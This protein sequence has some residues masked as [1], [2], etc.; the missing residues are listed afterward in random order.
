MPQAQERVSEKPMRQIVEVDRFPTLPSVAMEAIRLMEGEHSSFDSIADLLKS[1]QVLAGRI[2]HYANS[3]YIGARQ[4]VTSISQAIS[5]LGFN[6]LRSIIL[7]VS[8]FDCFTG[9]LAR[10]KKNLVNFWLHSIGVAATAEILAE[11]LGFESPAEAYVAGL[12]H[13]LGKLVCYLESPTDFEKVCQELEQQG[14]YSV[15]QS[16]PLDVERNIL[17]IRHIEAGK[18]LGNQW[19]LPEALVRVM[20]LHH[21]PVF[22]TI[23]PDP[24]NLPQLIRFADVLCVTHNVGSSYFMTSG[25]YCHEHFHFA[26]E[27]LVLHHHLSPAEIDE[28]MTQV[29]ERV[30]EVSDV[31]GIWNEREYRKLVGSANVSLG[32]LSR[33][34][35]RH[36][37]RLVQSNQV[38]EAICEISRQFNVSSSLPETARAVVSSALKGFNV[39]RCLCLIRDEPNHQFIGKFFDGADYHDV[40]IPAH[41]AGLKEYTLNS[42]GSDIELEA[43]QRLEQT[44]VELS[45]GDTFGPGV[46]KIV[47]GSQFLATFFVA[48]SKSYYGENRI[49]GELVVDFSDTTSFGG[50]SLK[51]V[52]KHFEAFASAAGNAVQNVLLQSGLTKHAQEVA[53]T[54]R[55]MEESQRQLFHS[56]RLATVGRLAAGAAHEINNPLTIISLNIQIID[57]LL[58]KKKEAKELRDRLTVIAEQ[59]TRIS[60]IIQDLMGFARP[61]QPKFY[62]SS[63]AQIME[64]VLS[65]IEDRVSMT[66]ISIANKI[67]ADL[68]M[69]MVDPMQVEQVFMNLLINANH[70]MPD[71]GKITLTAKAT[72]GFVEVNVTD[73]GLGIPKKNLA[74]IFDPFFT[75]KKEGEGTGLGLAICNSIVEHNGGSL[76]VQ[77]EEGK[78]TS[79]TVQLPVD[80]GSRLRAMKES[81]E[82]KKTTAAKV[83]KEKCRILVIDDERILNDM[84]QDSLRSSGY[85]VDGA[86]DGVEGIGLLRYKKYHLVLLDIRMPR[87]D[88]LEVLKFIKDE[89]P[90]IKVIMVTGL[91]SKEEVRETVK[92]GAFACLKKPFRLE[93]VLETVEQATRTECSVDKRKKA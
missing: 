13:D 14:A 12:T 10:H 62:P 82:Q 70:A 19:G 3:I 16:L 53:E 68:P 76:R 73:T 41:V 89:Y 61:T 55:K 87:K 46:M 22:E 79:F 6:A 28:I 23:T 52:T 77:S 59:E 80:K 47:A 15:H 26:L 48:D 85:D 81:M 42:A 39:S 91:A 11:K 27:N 60:K 30:K 31:L 8:I 37:R 17:G 21:Q 29:H 5:L 69:I 56:H 64:K 83:E 72:N 32:S 78:G 86:Y 1:D 34:L 58:S 9:K 2:L 45:Q 44:T 92:H 35:E 54:S 24:A 65:V 36:N 18:M 75:T 63:A 67:P 84:L 4:K 38:L 93:K 71:G 43:A 74:K 40:N 25:P 88:G 7:S 50:E 57:R 90:D 49:L 20:W 66:K 33:N 51:G